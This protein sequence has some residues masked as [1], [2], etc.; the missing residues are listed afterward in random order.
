M[1]NV[2][3]SN[4]IRLTDMEFQTNRLYQT[5]DMGIEITFLY[6]QPLNYKCRKI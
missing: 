6:K 1:N 2:N 4:Y 5:I 3:A